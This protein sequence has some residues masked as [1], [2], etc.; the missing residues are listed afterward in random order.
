M[1][2]L[3]RTESIFTF[4]VLDDTDEDFF[5]SE[6]I[7]DSFN[8]KEIKP[9]LQYRL[10]RHSKYTYDSEDLMDILYGVQK[11]SNFAQEKRVRKSS[12]ESLRQEH[13][14]NKLFLMS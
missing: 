1:P 12:S 2:W 6:F 14:Q 11:W 3:D 4:Q 7:A 10:N 9:L 5:D 8:A 13:F